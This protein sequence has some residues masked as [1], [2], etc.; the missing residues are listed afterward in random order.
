MKYFICNCVNPDYKELGVKDVNEFIDFIDNA[1]SI[2][3]KEFLGNCKVKNFLIIEMG[4]FPN[5][6]NFYKN[7]GI[8]FYTHSMIEYFYK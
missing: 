1:E 6:F 3:K 4:K 5:D 8:F 7:G 2:I